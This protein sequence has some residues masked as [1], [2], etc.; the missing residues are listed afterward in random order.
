MSYRAHRSR[1]L[2][3]AA[4]AALAA[5]AFVGVA[6]ASAEPAEFW[7]AEAEEARVHATNE[8]NHIFTAGLVGNISCT[9]ATFDGTWEVVPSPTITVQPSYND[10]TFLTVPNVKVNMNGCEYHF[11]QPQRV[12]TGSHNGPFTGTVDVVCPAGKVI[13]FGTATCTVTVPSQSN[14]S[15]VTYTN[16]PAEPPL[17][18]FKKVTVESHV[19][20]ITY[21]ATGICN[22]VP[23]TRSDGEYEGSALAHAENELEEEVDAWVT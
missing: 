15:E 12:N 16:L 23:G 17:T 7:A 14:L 2:G 4:I 5:M 11:D 10:C 8:D 6:S 9:E 1:T 3:L 19:T 20:G 22:G 21:T 13:T 18:P